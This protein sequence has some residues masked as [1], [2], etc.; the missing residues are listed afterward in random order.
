MANSTFLLHFTTNDLLE[1][2]FQS[3]NRSTDEFSSISTLLYTTPLDLSPRVPAPVAQRFVFIRRCKSKE[4]RWLRSH[5]RE[6]TVET[7]FPPKVQAKRA[8]N[9]ETFCWL[10][11]VEKE[12]GMEGCPKRESKESLPLRGLIR[13]WIFIRSLW[14]LF[15]QILGMLVLSTIDDRFKMIRVLFASN[16]CCEFIFHVVISCSIEIAFCK[17]N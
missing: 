14:I 6:F 15:V 12:S 16:L 5:N 10:L 11:R 13:Q 17:I 4:R 7:E 8:S 1:C 2:I 9:S 3:S